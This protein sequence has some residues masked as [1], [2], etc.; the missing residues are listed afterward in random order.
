VTR[1][2][3]L[4]L[5][6]L[7]CSS[8]IDLMTQMPLLSECLHRLVPSFSLSMIR[9]DERCVP[10][11]HYSEF[12][13]EESH[14]LFAMSGDHFATRSPDPAAFANLMGNPSPVGALVDGRPEYVEGMIYQHL[15]QPNGI[16]HTLDVALR[17]GAEPLA[18]L[19]IFRE[20]RA[21]GFTR[22]DVQLVRSVYGHLVHAC[23][24]EVSPASFDEQSSAMIVVDGSGR[25]AWASEAARA[26][27]AE[28]SFGSDRVLLLEQGLVPEVCRALMAMV[29]RARS[30]SPVGGA[31]PVPHAFIPVPGGR[32]SLRGYALEGQG[33]APDGYV[34]VQVSLQLDR[35]LRTL[36]ALS[37]SALT[38][39]QM[40]IAWGMTEGHGNAELCAALELGASTLKSYQKDMYRRLDV[41]SAGE[42][43]LRVSE[44]SAA[45]SLPRTRHQPGPATASS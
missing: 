27:L 14:A 4:A 15:F 17:D 6:R 1:A 20:R 21:P 45:V 35:R 9:V 16:H 30:L 33:G 34:G 3:D 26:W 12:F 43:V 22:E 38:P 10:Q 28:A 11:A 29:R 5:L 41:S 42:L 18:I 23:R 37:A 19:G 13:S 44:L 31:S 8:G 40:R 7:L 25:I 39:Q 32:V 36:R 24:A 2:K